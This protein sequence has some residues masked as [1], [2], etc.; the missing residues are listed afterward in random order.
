MKYRKINT[1]ERN[2]DAGNLKKYSEECKYL[3]PRES[4]YA[5]P[6][7]LGSQ[8]GITLWSLIQIDLMLD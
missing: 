4:G 7:E 3:Y 8:L 5:V 2:K 1:T 6:T